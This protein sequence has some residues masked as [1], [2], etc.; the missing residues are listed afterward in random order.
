MSKLKIKIWN[1][2][3]QVSVG[4][5]KRRTDR[6]RGR[7]NWKKDILGLDSAKIKKK[8]GE[9]RGGKFPKLQIIAS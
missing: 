1:F 3:I 8:N 2:K 9:A 5:R 7:K 4:S 6:K